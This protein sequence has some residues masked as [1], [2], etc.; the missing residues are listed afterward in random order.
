MSV[1]SVTQSKGRSQGGFTLMEMLVVVAIIA[2]LVAIAIPV[3]NA[4]LEKSRETYD[5]YT[6]RQAASLAVKYYY[7]GVKDKPSAEAAKLL[8]NNSG[9]PNQCNAYGVYNPTTGEFEDK[10]SQGPTKAYGKGTKQSTS[11]TY[12]YGDREIYKTGEDYTNAVVLVSIYPMGNNKHI[13]VYWKNKKG[14]YI[15]GDDGP[16]NPKYSIRIDLN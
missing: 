3:L 11:S 5:V 16:N 7:E 2:V 1:M 6:M 15:G 9:D 13:D 8:W 4:Q 14:K 10:G 12:T